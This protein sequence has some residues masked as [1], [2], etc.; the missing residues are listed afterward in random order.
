MS[1]NDP[2]LI[3][4][5]I[6]K[7]GKLKPAEEILFE[8]VTKGEIT[9]RKDKKENK[10]P[11]N[12]SMWG[13]ERVV[14]AKCVEWLCRDK[15]ALKFVTH[16]GIQVKGVR[17]DEELSLMFAKI[18][19]PLVI[20]ECAMLSG[21]D[22]RHTEIQM[23]S[24]LGTRT[25][26]IRADGFKVE[27][28]LLLRKGKAVGGVRLVGATIAGQLACRGGEF[29]NSPNTEGIALNLNSLDI[30]GSVFLDQGFKAQ[31]V[32]DLCNATIG[33]QLDC[34]DGEFINPNKTALNGDG[35]KVKRN[36]LLHNGF[37]ANGKVDLRGAIIGG[38]LS[39]NGGEFINPNGTAL[40][41]D[42]L[43]VTENIFFCKGFK[44]EGKV[45]L[46][47]AEIGGVFQCS[48]VD[49][50]EKMVLDLRFASINTFWDEQNSWP[51]RGR[52]FLNGF[53]YDQIGDYAPK[54][55][56][57]RIEWIRRQYDEQAEA[58]K[59][60]FRPQP[61]E[62]LAAVFRNSGRDEDAKKILIEKNRDK[63]RLTNLTLSEQFLHYLSGRTIG[64]GYRP[65]RT[66]WYGLVIVL[67]G[68]LLFWAGYRADVMIP[69]NENA[70]ASG[71]F[72]ALVYSLDVFVPLVDLR[73]ASYRMPNA[74]HAGNVR[75]LN[76]LNI[77]VSGKVL[78]Y[79]FWVEIIA[80]WV[81]TTLLI[82]GVTGLVRT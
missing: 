18:P 37:K 77:P 17:I 21:I 40:N 35:L 39:C 56:K 80:G 5:A 3:E 64:Y 57:S 61:Y 49:S 75:I 29:I 59:E 6:Q 23:L 48:G 31:G 33:G 16:K 44:A 30:T 68:W 9:D 11:G 72:S 28:D 24:L 52:L 45:N 42:S 15:E 74:N 69:A 34:N 4:L 62:Q 55:T 81:L 26:R 19:F 12:A 76:K 27:G 32:V 8:N 71:G 66:V 79:Y 82:V 58:D 46:I 63:A 54:D 53:T 47:K 67:I 41:G 1:K 73:Q 22:L 51:A 60:Q 36:V 10:D 25:G 7:F 20:M 43:K 78:R 14:R 38:Q 13:N 70:D 50:P 2:N 65:W